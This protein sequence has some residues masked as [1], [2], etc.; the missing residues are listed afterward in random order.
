MFLCVS[1]WLNG[2]P[3]LQ[4]PDLPLYLPLNTRRIA[5]EGV[6]WPTVS[7]MRAYVEDCAHRNVKGL[8][9]RSFEAYYQQML[10][11]K[12]VVGRRASEIAAEVRMLGSGYAAV[13]A[14]VSVFVDATSGFFQG[15][16]TRR[17]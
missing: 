1:L 11:I 9:E 15:S 14:R 3:P 6:Q 13:H 16:L 17:N 10:K 5:V 12:G 4:T 8:P 2:C 7:T